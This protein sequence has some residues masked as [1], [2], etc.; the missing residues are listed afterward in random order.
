MLLGKPFLITGYFH[1]PRNLISY[2]WSKALNATKTLPPHVCFRQEE[3]SRDTDTLAQFLIPGQ[4]VRGYFSN[5]F[6]L[7]HLTPWSTHTG[8][9]AISFSL[10]QAALWLLDRFHSPEL[11]IISV[12]IRYPVRSTSHL[13][14]I[15]R[16]I[17]LICLGPIPLGQPVQKV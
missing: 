3:A 10:W 8:A 16:V 7:L 4:Q 1:L 6:N 9:G 11:S 2:P 5:R 17:P 15:C 14:I 13:Q 12:S